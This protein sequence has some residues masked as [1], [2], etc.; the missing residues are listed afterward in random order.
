MN[1]HMIVE[2]I[3]PE[4]DAGYS[5]W[6]YDTEKKI[7]SLMSYLSN[8]MDDPEKEDHALVFYYNGTLYR[9]KLNDIHKRRHDPWDPEH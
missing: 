2:E 6:A 3:P 1:H 5:S 7:D 8:I 4:Y 9:F